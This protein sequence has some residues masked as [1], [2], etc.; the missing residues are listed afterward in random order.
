[1]C[2]VACHPKGHVSFN[3]I[4]KR[5]IFTETQTEDSF[6]VC[7]LS[8]CN[9]SETNKFCL[10]A[11]L[12]LCLV[13]EQHKTSSSG[14]EPRTVFRRCFVRFY[15]LLFETNNFNLGAILLLCLVSEL[16]ETP[17]PG[18]GLRALFTEFWPSYIL[19]LVS[20]NKHTKFGSNQFIR[21]RAVSERIH[22]P[23]NL[24]FMCKVT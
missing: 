8:S 21:S 19:F 22:K 7:D 5:K 12:L 20:R 14:L 17:F 9:L 11:F 24:N 6:R 18:I 15:N 16:Q 23:H 13:L 1:V 2:Y 4:S 3:I 10:G